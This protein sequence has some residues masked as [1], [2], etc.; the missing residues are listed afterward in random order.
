MWRSGQ[1]LQRRSGNGHAFSCGYVWLECLAKPVSRVS[2]RAVAAAVTNDEHFAQ[3]TFIVERQFTMLCVASC[4]SGGDFGHVA[5]VLARRREV[6][7]FGKRGFLPKLGLYRPDLIES[8]RYAG[9][10]QLLH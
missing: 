1:L 7:L 3:H 9:K 2:R 4:Q 8:F 6:E 5:F 10:K